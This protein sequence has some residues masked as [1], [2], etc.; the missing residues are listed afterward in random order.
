MKHLQIVANSPIKAAARLAFLLLLLTLI[1]VS[2]RAQNMVTIAGVDSAGFCGDKGPAAKAALSY[3]DAIAVDAKGNI[4]IG[5]DH[6]NRIRMIDAHTGLITTVAGTGDAGYSGDGSLAVNAEIDGPTAMVFDAEGNMYFGDEANACIR[7]IDAATHVITTIAGTGTEAYAGDGGPAVEASFVHPSGL[8]IDKDGNLYVADWGSS[9]VRKINAKTGIITTIAGTG[10]GDFYGDGGP[11]D[12]AALS[13]CNELAIDKD[14]NIYVTDS[15]NNRIRKID[16]ETGMINTV[17]GNGEQGYTGNGGEAVNATLNGPTGLAVDAD[18][19]VYFSDY[20]NNCIRSINNNT[21]V[22]MT[23]AGDGDYG[24]S[25]DGEPALMAKI[26]GAE[27]IAIDATGNIYIADNNNNRVRKIE[28]EQQAQAISINAD[29]SEMLLYPNPSRDVVNVKVNQDI[30]EGSTL[31][32][33]TI[34]GQEVWTKNAEAHTTTFMFSVSAL[35]SGLYFLKLQSPDG[36]T[37]MKKLQ[38]QK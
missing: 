29:N 4:Y 34:T 27:G 9:T 26:A 15:Y 8:V 22:I 33:F 18:G 36:T 7:K 14:G 1:S 35:Q 11:A 24:F 25:G 21:G 38:V 20:G 28:K 23:V 3:P 10:E 2:L 13:G 16:A 37:S 30:P 5:D 6:N 12:K 32:L 19:T 17:A 31:T